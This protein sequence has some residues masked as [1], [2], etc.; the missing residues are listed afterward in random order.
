MSTLLAL[1]IACTPQLTSPPV[2]PSLSTDVVSTDVAPAAEQHR[3]VMSYDEALANLDTNLIRARS[4]AARYA[5]DGGRWAEVAALWATRGRMTGSYGDLARAEDAYSVSF[6]LAPEGAGPLLGRARL[7]LS[8][9]RL[10]AAEADL[11]VVDGHLMLDDSKQAEILRLRGDLALQRGEIDDATALYQRSMALQPTLSAR[12]GLT[13][14]QLWRGEHDAT[15]AGLDEVEAMVVG[16]APSVRM[17]LELQRG[18]VELSRE[19][20]DEALAHYLDAE[21]RLPGHWLVA[22]H[23]A[24][25]T[26]L[27][28][29]RDEA[30]ERYHAVVVATGHPEFMDAIAGLHLGAGDAKTAEPWLARAE[31]AYARQLALFPEAAAGHALDHLLEHGSDPAQAVTLALANVATRPNA[32]AWTKLATAHRQASE[33]TAA[34][35][36]LDQAIAQGWESLDRYEEERALAEALG[37]DARAGAATSRIAALKVGHAG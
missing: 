24:E 26:A 31:A 32:E 29:R 11:D 14:L 10:D 35:H 9:H 17:W 36:A 1:L 33:L 5:T 2:A 7:H 8:L 23:I 27:L 3:P 28:G 4:L 21:A 18:I 34:R 25:V 37:D 19:R 30:L 13:Q 16:D 12:Y 20:Y 22:E 6:A 15:L